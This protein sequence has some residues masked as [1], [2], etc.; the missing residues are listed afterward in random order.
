MLIANN[1]TQAGID[2]VYRDGHPNASFG[3]EKA[4]GKNNASTT[5]TIPLTSIFG[6]ILGDLQN[7]SQSKVSNG[8]QSPAVHMKH[9]ISTQ[10]K[11]NI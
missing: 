8:Y 7:F 11:S 1:N 2:G 5:T 9:P 3:I 6:R 10:C 4:A